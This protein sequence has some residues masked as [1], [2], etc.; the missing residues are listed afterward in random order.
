VLALAVRHQH[1]LGPQ[2]DD[3]LGHA[4][5]VLCLACER[6]VA[7]GGSGWVARTFQMP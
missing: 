7:D 6:R 3:A 5:V 2:L 4:I 1:A